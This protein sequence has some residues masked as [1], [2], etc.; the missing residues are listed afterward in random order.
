MGTVPDS[1]CRAREAGVLLGQRGFLRVLNRV[2]VT[3]AHGV[4]LVGVLGKVAL[5]RAF[6]TTIQRARV[7]KGL[8]LLVLLVD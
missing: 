7:L 3:R 6:S 4:L 1:V 8:L 2:G 5:L